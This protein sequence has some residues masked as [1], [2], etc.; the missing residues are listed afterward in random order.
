M[1]SDARRRRA[2]ASIGDVLRCGSGLLLGLVFAV[3]CKLHNRP[4][5]PAVPVGPDSAEVDWAYSFKTWAVGGDSGPV[6]IRFDWD[7][8]DT[9]SWI[10]PGD[11]AECSHMWSHTGVYRV[12]A[13]VHDS[14]AEQSD[15]SE[16]HSVTVIVPP[17]PYRLVDSVTVIDAPLLDAQVLPNGEF[18]YVTNDFEGALSVV[19]TADL[20]LVA[21]TPF[22]EG[23]SSYGQAVCSPDGQYVYAT[24]YTDDE[25]VAVVRTADNVVVDSLMV[26]GVTCEAVSPDG[27]HLYVAVSADS[28]FILVLRLPGLTVEDTI[29]MS[30]CESDISSLLVGID[31]T[32]LYFGVGEWEYLYAVRLH[33]HA[34]LWHAAGC[35]G[36]TWPGTFALDPSGISLYVVEG[37]YVTVRDPATGVLRDTMRIPDLESIDISPDGS[38]LFVACDRGDS[39]SVAVVRTS[40]KSV[41]RTITLPTFVYDAAPSPDDQRLYATGDNGKLYVVGR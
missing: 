14:R 38:F 32:C 5:A 25:D 35:G 21:Q 31:G 36:F 7:D 12:R 34:V 16:P 1:D 8:G 28:I 29:G 33:D 17:Y 4:E 26:D 30:W 41:V 3:S 9:S 10:F 24:E 27:R 13:Q 39:G 37:P 19:R 6:H 11:T 18:V 22:N 15:W 40:D 23:W 2:P 20:R